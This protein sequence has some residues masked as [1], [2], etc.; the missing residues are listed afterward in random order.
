MACGT[1][2]LFSHVCDC[3]GCVSFL[4]R[5]DKREETST[6]N[7][8][9]NFLQPQMSPKSTTDC[10]SMH[11]ANMLKK[12]GLSL[13]QN[14]FVNW[15]TFAKFNFSSIWSSLCLRQQEIKQNCKRRRY[16]NRADRSHLFHGSTLRCTCNMEAPNNGS[17]CWKHRCLTHGPDSD[18][19][20]KGW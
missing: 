3:L 15:H 17:S 11:R 8:S 10:I 14:D 5:G 18:K 16:S 7:I 19:R 6:T 2:R 12:S 13:R 1:H 9:C 20:S 4:L